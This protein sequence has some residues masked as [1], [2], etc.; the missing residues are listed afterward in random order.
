MSNA[1]R[2]VNTMLTEV[3]KNIRYFR[4][5]KKLTQRTLA[6]KVLVSYQSISAWERGQSVPDLENAV[7]LSRFFGITLDQLV[8]EIK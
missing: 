1:L 7:C 5:Q 4:K 6:Q 2:K 8:S 3:G